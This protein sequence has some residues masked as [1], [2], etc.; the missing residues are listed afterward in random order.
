MRVITAVSVTVSMA[1]SIVLAAACGKK[2]DPNPAASGSAT[3]V[4][5]RAQDAGAPPA[6]RADAA[7]APAPTYTKAQRDEY[8]KH[9]AAGRKLGASKKWGEA[10]AEFEAALAVIPMDGRALA[11]LG[12]AAY[13][14]GDFKKA[15]KANSDA[16]R[17]AG[18]P[19]LRAA[20]YYNL[21][22][23]AVAEHDDA[24]AAEAFRA[25]LALRPGNAAVEKALAKLGHDAPAP[26]VRGDDIACST[27]APLDDI[28]ACLVKEATDAGDPGDTPS[29]EPQTRGGDDGSEISMPA[30]PPAGFDVVTVTHSTHELAAFL[31][32]GSGKKW[33]VVEPIGTSYNP[34]SFGI[35]ETLSIDKIEQRKVGSH[36]VL[37]VET[38]HSHIDNDAGINESESTTTR[39]VLLCP[40][41][42]KIRCALGVT[43]DYSYDRS[44]LIEDEE[45]NAGI[46]HTPGLPITNRRTL[47]LAIAD[48]GTATVTLDK[49][50][51]PESPGVLGPHRL[52]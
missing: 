16:I 21:G 29:C 12:L 8:R 39:D 42:A 9:L 26:G 33:R 36:A 7:I 37:W 38:T 47:A 48:D 22:L 30:S 43:L 11:E 27:P 50:T 28:C 6:T 20:G 14:A 10:T 51:A 35:S 52:W 45:A 3:P 34:G 24:A 49:G 1:V 40:L 5:A 41:T 44:I 2:A 18:E 25:S 15:R 46:Q 19:K 4:A 32:A 17:V 23:V 31:V 13:A